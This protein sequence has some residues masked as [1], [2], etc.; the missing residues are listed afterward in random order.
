MK[1]RAR[2]LFATI[3]AEGALLPPEL[4]ARVA[5]NDRSLEGLA[6]EAYHLG[7]GERLGE[8]INRSWSRL[9][10]L[11]SGFDAAREAMP[12]RDA[13]TTLTRERWLLA[14]YG[15]LG[16]GRLAPARAV[17]LDGHTYP[18]SHAWHRSPIH[19]VSFRVDLDRRTAGVAGAARQSPHSLVQE[20]LNRSDDRLW[21][22]VSNGLQLRLLR[23]NAS[24]TRQAYVEWD[25]EA[26]MRGEVYADFVVLWLVCHQ[27][28][29]EAEQPADC[30]L[31]R[32]SRTAVEQG[33]R[34]L[35]QLRAGVEEAI[36][37]LGRGYL[38]HPA[39]GALRD[40]LR[41]GE[42]DGLGLYRQLLRVVYRLLLQF[43]AE[44]RDVLHEPG[45]DPAARERFRRYYSTQRL[46]RIAEQRRG[47]RHPDLHAALRFVW[48]RLGA[49]EGCPELALPGLGGLLFS[50][51]ATPALDGC[52][53]ANRDLL[54]AVRAL[55]LAESGGV[56]R[57]VDFKNLGSEE[58]G[59]VYE[60]LLE[61]HPEIDA[62][63]G[64]FALTTA[65]GHERKTTGSYYTPT[66]LI[67]SL[68]D[69]ALDPVLDEAARAD[70]PEQA[71]LALSVCDP[72][73]GSG[74]FLIAAAHRI[75]KRLA[76]VRTGDE[77]PAPAAYRAALRDVIGHCLYG[78]DVNP[79]AVELC[80]VGL[81]MEALEPGRPLG[82]LDHRIVCGNS[83][84]G[85]TPALIAQG[86][87]AEAFAAIGQLDRRF[88]EQVRSVLAEALPG[89]ENVSERAAGWAAL[90][91]DAV[92]DKQVAAELRK[93]ND[94]ERRSQGA[95]AL[96]DPAAVVDANLADAVHA[97]D[98]QPERSPAD[99]RRKAERY[100]AA[101][102]S[103]EH[104][105]ARLLADAWCAAFVGAKQPGVEAVTQATLD[106][107]SEDPACL[108]P[109]VRAVVDRTAERMRFFHWHVAFPE[110]FRA[111]SGADDAEP[112]GWSGG[113]DVVLGNPPWEHTELKETE[114]FAHEA[115]AIAGAA[116]KAARQRAIAALA[117]DQR[118]L[119][120]RFLVA[121]READAVSHLIRRSGRFPLCA[122]GR[123][124]TYAIFAEN[125]RTI[126]AADGQVG[127]IVPTGIATDDTTKVFFREIVERR[128]L[129]SLYDFENREG[130]F[131]AVHR[132]YKFCLLTLGGS[133]EQ[134][135]EAQ[136]VFYATRVD[137][138]ADPERR[139]TLTLEDL[140]LLNP[141]SR[142]CP[143]F[144]S[145]RDAE[146][147]KEI[148]RRVPVL[149]RERDPLSDP[150]GVS[151]R[152]GLFNMASDSGLFRGRDELEA[153]GCSLTGNV[154][155]CERRRLLPLYE[156][157]MLHHFNHRYGDYAMRPSGSQDAQ[158]PDVPLE[159]LD[160]PA[161][162]PLPRYWVDAAEVEQRLSNRWGHG[163]LLGWRDIARSSDER[164]V[165]AGALSP[166]A[167]G[168]TMP[169]FASTA[170]PAAIAGLIGALSS[171]V[172]DYGA[173]QKV[174]GTHVTFGFMQQ[175]PLPTPEMLA[176]RLPW[177]VS[178]VLELTYTAWDLAPFAADLDYVG[179]PFRW[180][181]ERR[182]LL[183][184]ELDAAFFHIYGV[185]RDD[186]DYILDT[187]PIVRRKDEQRYGEYRTKRVILEIYDE[188]AEAQRTGGE[189]VTRLDPPPADPAVAHAGR[190]EMRRTEEGTTA[191]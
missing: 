20:L 146:I 65:G 79:M 164:T 187:F 55:S 27:S 125:D 124:N 126:I 172:L 94:R 33:T 174:G 191:V 102:A 181:R 182:F 152:Q 56:R 12:E 67:V 108:D 148:Y 43:A 145:R 70:N 80:K 91:R 72:A 37:C 5:E 19:L 92:D 6:P 74:H 82:F 14:L 75:A 188:M 185:E 54:D 123:I 63:A 137:H 59:S 97:L 36:A 31:E 66:S 133:R 100:A 71:I 122:R 160:D 40:A 60:S 136:F 165:I 154:F 25:L 98:A 68:L 142:T 22:F 52:E 106:Q 105:R 155:E 135:A 147:T 95:F 118:G 90:V 18:V 170:S 35:D 13:G 17:E 180:D 138:L 141:N 162:A 153:E 179:P 34:A 85:T 114:F 119:L 53:L 158:L 120:R 4:L 184:A 151:F 186:V 111:A 1:L 51:D 109:D 117:R 132:S 23:D 39:N 62:D 112:A 161:Y 113:F 139:F 140:A 47:A 103:P 49:D 169:L 168:H 21:G 42:L 107:I 46:R 127:C 130:L 26:M 41:S 190:S 93:R 78:V 189:Y 88:E 149:L 38:A 156:A 110:I 9:L 16:Y 99:V 11:W 7:P 76:A 129:V 57:P 128:S 178:R 32:W 3:R 28:R 44:D 143:T 96:G 159:R 144:R 157:K 73:C 61:L 30:L 87:P 83:L 121:R 48:Q 171:F 89:S 177:L 2:D 163:W 58:L 173:R 104:E 77:E 84:L 176:D 86:I 101:Q 64:H 69:S 8:A 134:S 24:L 167:V 116:N 115:P 166:Y 175:L 45:A 131:P 50:G 183:R 15:E 150:W 29:V 81:W 10:G